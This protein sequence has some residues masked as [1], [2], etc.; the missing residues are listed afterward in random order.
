MRTNPGYTIWD[1]GTIEEYDR[2]VKHAETLGVL[3]WQDRNKGK[4]FVSRFEQIQQ[5]FK[6]EALKKKERLAEGQR[7]GSS[8]PLRR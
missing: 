1:V 2:A 3:I 8:T 6:N 4:F 7:G 5:Y